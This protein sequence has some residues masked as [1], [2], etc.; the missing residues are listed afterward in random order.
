MFFII[1]IDFLEDFYKK[2]RNLYLE[3]KIWGGYNSVKSCDDKWL[4]CTC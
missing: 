3:D 1:Y 4:A 2:C